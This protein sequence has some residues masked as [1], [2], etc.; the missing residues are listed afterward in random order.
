M[1]LI[2][3]S[4]G[5]GGSHPSHMHYSRAVHSDLLPKAMTGKGG[6]KFTK[7]THDEHG[8]TLKLNTTD[9]EPCW[10]YAPLMRCSENGAF[11]SGLPPQNAG[12]QSSHVKSTWQIPLEGHSTKITDQCSS[13]G[14]GHQKRENGDKLPQPRG[15]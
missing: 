11:P 6:S 2:L 5:G 14:K 13:N 12:P 8:L 15:V 9:D 3:C 4:Q 10:Q 1:L 7:E